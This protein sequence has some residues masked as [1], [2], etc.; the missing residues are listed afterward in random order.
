MGL[1]RTDHT[2]LLHE[3]P[4]LCQKGPSFFREGPT[5]E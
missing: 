5:F 1:G 3:G 2:V 4:S